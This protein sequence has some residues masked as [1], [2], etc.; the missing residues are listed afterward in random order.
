MAAM[1]A[2][3]IPSSDQLALTPVAAAEVVVRTVLS[4]TL[5]QDSALTDEEVADVV[6]RAITRH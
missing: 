3:A 5:I 6:S 4:H 1:V 2:Q